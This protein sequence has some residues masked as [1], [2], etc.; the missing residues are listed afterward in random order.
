MANEA[1]LITETS[2]P[3]AFTVADGTGIEKGAIL[4][5]TDPMT[6]IINSAADDEIAGVAASEKIADDGKVKLGV[7]RG[8]IFKVY[9]SGS[10][11]A[12]D[13]LTTSTPA[14]YLKAGATANVSGS[15]V[16]GIALETGT[17]G[18]TIK[19]ELRPQA[20]NNGII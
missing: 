5:L 11:T 1:T 19:A 10:A 8:G 15:I 7:Y 2:P 6:A 17:T 14:N 3:I 9:L 13:I 4:K 20:V 16:F 18:Q 12:G